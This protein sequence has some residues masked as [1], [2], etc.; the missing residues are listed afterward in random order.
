MNDFNEETTIVTRKLIPEDQRLKVT[1]D[2]FGYHFPLALEPTIYTIASRM[3]PEY[4]GGFWQ[5]WR[6]DNG[7]FL[8]TPDDDRI[9][10]VQSA[11]GWEGQLRG[12]GLGWV[13]CL[14]A[15]SH[16]SFSRNESLAKLCARHYHLLRPALFQLD[17]EVAAILYAID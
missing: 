3:A 8:M 6:F 16:L 14:T 5:F 1:A 9:F 12:Q 11:N 17:D 7:A 4:H 2:L 15:Y 10:T 13:V